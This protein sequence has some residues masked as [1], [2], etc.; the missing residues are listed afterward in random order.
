VVGHLD[1]E[2]AMLTNVSSDPGTYLVIRL[3]GVRSPR[4][5][6]GTSVTVRAGDHSWTRQLT[7]GESYQSS[8]QHRLTF[9]LGDRR[10][11]DELLVTW[12]SGTRQRF[13]DVPLSRELVLVEG[14]PLRAEN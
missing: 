8:S 6:V 3:I 4:D 12:P 7:A 14:G 2:A 1:D 9:G 5:A 13:G 10:E 11:I